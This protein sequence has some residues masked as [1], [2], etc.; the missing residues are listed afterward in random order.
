MSYAYRNPVRRREDGPRMVQGK[1]GARPRSGVFSGSVFVG[2][3]L[4]AMLMLLMLTGAS[5][6]QSFDLGGQTCVQ[7]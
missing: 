6:A 1:S 7:K 5:F 2:T 4:L 3:R